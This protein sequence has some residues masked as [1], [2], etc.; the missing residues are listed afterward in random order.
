MAAP[1]ELPRAGHLL[2]PH[3]TDCPA[4]R[5]ALSCWA[6]RAASGSRLEVCL[7]AAATTGVA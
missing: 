3:M 5:G 2:T 6:A 7:L 1:P 4:S